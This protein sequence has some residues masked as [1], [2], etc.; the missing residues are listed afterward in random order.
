MCNLTNLLKIKTS[1]RPKVCIA[2]T[3]STLNLKDRQSLRVK[4]TKVR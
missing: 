1:L 3:S 2:Q 4:G